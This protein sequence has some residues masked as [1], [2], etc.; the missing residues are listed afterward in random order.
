LNL[1]SAEQDHDW[2]QAGKLRSSRADRSWRDGEVYLARDTKLGREVAIKLVSPC[3]ANDPARLER[4]QREARALASL[5]H[6]NIVTIH[7]VE[8]AGGVHFLTMELLEGKT[9]SNL[10]DR[11][12]LSIGEFFKLAIPLADALAA[13]H[14]KGISHRD[15]KPGNI[16]VVSEDRLKVLDFGLAKLHTEGPGEAERRS[17]L[18]TETVEE[19]LTGEGRVVGTAVGRETPRPERGGG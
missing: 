18:P 10:I 16:M 1:I 5:N 12:G 13:A 15:L 7:S 19:P 14:A 11:R 9:L 6:P 8:E 4:F 3:L 17:D 2:P